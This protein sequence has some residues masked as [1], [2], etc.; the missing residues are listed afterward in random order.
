MATEI[1][2]VETF[3]RACEDDEFAIADQ[4]VREA[5]VTLMRTLSADLPQGSSVCTSSCLSVILQSVAMMMAEIDSA[6]TSRILS[7]LGASAGDIDG[8]DFVAIQNAMRLQQQKLMQAELRMR[9]AHD[10]GGHA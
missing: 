8:G 7:L 4:L 6:A 10:A 9:T 2:N 1:K 5:T 3:Y